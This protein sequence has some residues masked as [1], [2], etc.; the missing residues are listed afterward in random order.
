MG[1]WGWR[2]NPVPRVRTPGTKKLQVRIRYWKGVRR[3]SHFLFKEKSN[4]KKQSLI[5]LH[6]LLATCLEIESL[7]SHAK[8]RWKAN[9]SIEIYIDI[10]PNIDHPIQF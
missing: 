6:K 1:A 3:D 8:K 7:K 10:V 4:K 9:F 2:P 5:N